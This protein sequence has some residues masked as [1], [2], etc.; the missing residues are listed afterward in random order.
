MS[1]KNEMPMV[2]SAVKEMFLLFMLKC[3]RKLC[4]QRPLLWTNRGKVPDFCPKNLVLSAI[5]LIFADN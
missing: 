2:G 3:P 5:F 4:G 1:R